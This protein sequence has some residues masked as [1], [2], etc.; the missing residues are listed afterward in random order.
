MNRSLVLTIESSECLHCSIT[1]FKM[2]KSIISNLLH[3]LNWSMIGKGLVDQLLGGS[4]HEV[5]HIQHLH[6]CNNNKQ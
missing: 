6:L 1:S 4:Q 5:P 2:Y 3:S